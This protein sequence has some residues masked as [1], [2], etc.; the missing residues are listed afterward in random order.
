[1]TDTTTRKQAKKTATQRHALGPWLFAILLLALAGPPALAQTE[2]EQAP[3]AFGDWTLQ[4]GKVGASQETSCILVQDVTEQESGRPVMQFAVGFWGAEKHRGIV[5][6]LPLGVR[7]PPGIQM[8][9]DATEVGNLP[10][11]QCRQ[12]GCQ[13]HANLDDALLSKFKAGNAGTV[14]FY[15]GTGRVIPVPFSLK[16]F[17]AGF[18]QVN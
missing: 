18:A 2:G 8:K 3:R 6:T 1:M 10:F 15:D 7:L 12:N 17:T 13:V 9:V 5:I 16:G 4:C 14:S 11:F